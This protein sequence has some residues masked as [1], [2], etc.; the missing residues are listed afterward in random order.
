MQLNPYSIKET[1]QEVSDPA[2][3]VTCSNE[4]DDSIPASKGQERLE[5]NETS[6]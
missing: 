1:E 6:P 2:I 3:K 5:T 4:R